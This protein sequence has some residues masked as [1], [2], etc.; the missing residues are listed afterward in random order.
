MKIPLKMGNKES[1]LVASVIVAERNAAVANAKLYGAINR[2]S[3]WSRTNAG[4]YPALDE[5]VT[6]NCYQS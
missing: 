1:K 2:C 5:S 3:S 4:S 6:H